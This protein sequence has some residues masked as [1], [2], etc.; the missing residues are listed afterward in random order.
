MAKFSDEEKKRR[1]EAIKA[2]NKAGRET[3]QTAPP[4]QEGATITAEPG[5]VAELAELDQGEP[6]D[7]AGLSSINP[8]EAMEHM[9]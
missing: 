7:G 1:S 6:D 4:P 8:I 5:P 2:R 3:A 9:S